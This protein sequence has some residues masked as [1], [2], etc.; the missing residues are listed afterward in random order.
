[1]IFWIAV[2]SLPLGTHS[3]YQLKMLGTINCLSRII[4]HWAL[5]PKV[6]IFQGWTTDLQSDTYLCI[7]WSGC[8]EVACWRPSW[9]WGQN[10]W[11]FTASTQMHTKIY[12]RSF[13]MLSVRSM[14]V[15]LDWMDLTFSVV[16]LSH[17]GT[18]T[19]Q[20]STSPQCCPGRRASPPWLA[21][22]LTWVRALGRAVVTNSN[23]FVVHSF[24]H[25]LLWVQPPVGICS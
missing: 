6:K 3:L 21:P 8:Q 1:M 15:P 11:A 12:K 22:S 19:S 10:N 14:G 13:Q 20:T 9:S 7:S 5:N 25:H 2:G 17:Q 18:S 4:K 24:R 23:A 16:P